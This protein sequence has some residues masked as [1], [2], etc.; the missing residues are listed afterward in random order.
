MLRK[1]R[2]ETAVTGRVAHK[3]TETSHPTRATGKAIATSLITRPVDK[4]IAHSHRKS[5]IHQKDNT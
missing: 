1:R 3:S 5:V 2:E 4:V